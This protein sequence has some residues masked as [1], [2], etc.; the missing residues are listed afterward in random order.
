MYGSRKVQAVVEFPESLQAEL[1]P[2]TGQPV[3]FQGE[4]VRVDGLMRS[5]FVARA[6]RCP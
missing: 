2:L 4:V 1:L 5:I 3:S 6:E